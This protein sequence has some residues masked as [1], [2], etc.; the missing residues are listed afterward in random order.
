VA[1]ETFVK[2]SQHRLAP[3]VVQALSSERTAHL[4]KIDLQNQSD[5]TPDIKKKFAESKRALY[6]KVTEPSGVDAEKVRAGLQDIFKEENDQI[7]VAR[8]GRNIAEL[9]KDKYLYTEEPKTEP[10]DHSFWWAES[11][12]IT[13]PGYSGRFENDGLNIWGMAKVN[14]HDEEMRTSFG[15]VALFAINPNRIPDSPTGQLT[16]ARTLNSSVGFRLIVRTMICSRV[17]A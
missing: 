6:R 9:L 5:L 13:G 16:Q 1:D 14:G 11:Y 8:K 10:I 2:N 12:A 3:N 7:T 15:A 4:K 17:T